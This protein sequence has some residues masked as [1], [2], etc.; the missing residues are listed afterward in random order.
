MNLLVKLENFI[1]GL[2]FK[3]GELMWKLVP[4]PIKRFIEKFSENYDRILAFIKNLPKLILAAIPKIIAYAKTSLFADAKKAFEET[5]KAARSQYNGKKAKGLEQVKRTFLMPFLFVS[6]W[7][8]G[9]TPPQILL[10]LTFTGGSFLAVIGIGFSGNK[11]VTSNF[12][13]AGRMPASTDEIKYERP[14]Y[15]KSQT[16]HVEFTSFRLPV[17][18]AKVNEIRSVDIDFV[19]TLTNR[20]AKM[21][22]EKHDFQ[23]RDH[24]VL[25]I[26]PMIASFP[27]EDEGKEIIRKKL[28]ADINDFLIQNE[29]EGKVEDLKITY[30]L[31]N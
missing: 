22:L 28:E 13:S 6:Q 29:V 1:N 27:L 25:Q 15:Y 31:A 23:L 16:R 8:S 14:D 5:S 4:G 30:I 9:L 7:M 11:L 10:L 18:T 19:A 26:E 17:Y 12:G 3:L 20:N 2:L 21:F 24:L